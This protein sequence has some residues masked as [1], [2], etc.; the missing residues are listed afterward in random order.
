MRILQLTLAAVVL[1]VTTV[2]AQDAPKPGLALVVYDV[3]AL[4]TPDPAH[5]APSGPARLSLR[6]DQYGPT[7]DLPGS[8]SGPE[9]GWSSD[10]LM[11]AIG[12]LCT[13]ELSDVSWI[14]PPENGRLGVRA[15][16]EDHQ[17]IGMYLRALIAMRAAR[18]H[19]AIWNTSAESKLVGTATGRL[20]EDLIVGF[21]REDPQVLYHYRAAYT[22]DLARVGTFES[23]MEFSLCVCHQGPL[24]LVQGGLIERRLRGFRDAKVQSG[25][26]VN[27][28]EYEERSAPFAFTAVSG[29]RVALSLFGVPYA[30]DVSCDKSSGSLD[31]VVGNRRLY[32]QDLSPGWVR[33]QMAP[34]VFG[35][36]FSSM[37]TQWRPHEAV[38]TASN[39]EAKFRE[40][41]ME[42]LGRN[43]GVDLLWG[44]GF[45]C[46][47]GPAAGDDRSS[48]TWAGLIG[49]A[50][51]LAEPRRA[52]FQV[53]I[54]GRRDG[55]A[56]EET[57]LA[58]HRFSV[59]AGQMADWFSI[60]R[61]QHIAGYVFPAAVPVGIREPWQ[62]APAAGLQIRVLWDGRS[63]FVRAA[64]RE[65]IGPLERF[66]TR[67]EGRDD[68]V[69]ERQRAQTGEIY[70]SAVLNTG[71]R[72]QA[73]APFGDSSMIAEIHRVD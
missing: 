50:R 67:I 60:V 58:S 44:F 16:S 7:V 62:S 61:T 56:D 3:S 39:A 14:G 57:L 27:M 71:Q 35:S 46:A 31:A 55:S 10:A 30:I 70:T 21:T 41:A 29:S 6:P 53:E 52:V 12:G 38:N 59:C 11:E 66:N 65:V 13:A 49:D 8:S 25:M 69:I 28:A 5:T 42:S 32:M 17:L 40:S 64:R 68:I 54:R 33:S 36:D 1:S 72:T 37:R 47:S 4:S 34:W 26:V 22:A 73:R 63:V 18:V 45:I 2:I 15:A 24:L 48:T 20:N 23:G 43:A 9:Q 19:V 51:V